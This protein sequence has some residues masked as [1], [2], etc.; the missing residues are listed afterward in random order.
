MLR[1]GKLN[2]KCSKHI[3]LR[4]LWLNEEIVNGNV[5]VK[6]VPTT[7]MWADIVTKGVVGEDFIKQR[8]RLLG[9]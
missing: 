4:A 7:E 2:G 3:N 1:S 5:D 8:S 9:A 6:W